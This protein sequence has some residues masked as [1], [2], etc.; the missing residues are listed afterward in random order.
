MNQK[1]DI[2]LSNARQWQP[3]MTQLRKVMLDCGLTE[4]FKWGKPCYAFEGKNIVIIQGFRAY[5]AIL[6]FKGALLEDPHGVL[7]KTGENTV[8][9]RQIRVENVQEIIKMT[10]I[11]KSYIY[12]AIE[13]EKAGLKVP[14]KG[15]V[16]R[17]MPEELR[18]KLAGLPAL[19]AAFNAL[20]P[21]RQKAYIIYFSTP[22]QSRTRVS[23]IEKY[24]P[25][26][27]AGKGLHD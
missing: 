6:F 17:A 22:K 18:H 26:I 8:V 14:G 12:Q 27:L 13:V 20:T 19:E 21:G 23:R 11:L 3:E 4:E 9:G 16:T 10:P 1:V 7:R 15:K 25:Q 24:V 2:Y 5:C